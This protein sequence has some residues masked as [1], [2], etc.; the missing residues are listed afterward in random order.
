MNDDRRICVVSLCDYNNDILYGKWISITKFTDEEEVL[1]DIREMLKSS[2]TTAKTGKIA[3]EWEIHDYDNIPKILHGKNIKELIEALRPFWNM[4]DE[5]EEAYVLFLENGDDGYNNFEKSYQ[6][7]YH[8][9]KEYVDDFLE[10]YYSAELKG[11]PDIISI[12]TK[13]IFQDLIQSGYIWV[14]RGSYGMHVFFGY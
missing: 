10:E 3:E 12:D 14:E 7:C 4:S 2:P 1:E 9:K 6:G 8:N 11:L 5:E 13:R